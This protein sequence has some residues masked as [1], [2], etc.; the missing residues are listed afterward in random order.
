VVRFVKGVHFDPTG[1]KRDD[2]EI[3]EDFKL[4]LSNQT[5]RFKNSHSTISKDGT[6]LAK[7]IQ[8]ARS[9]TQDWKTFFITAG[10][11]VSELKK[12]GFWRGV[13]RRNIFPR[14]RAAYQGI[15]WRDLSIDLV[16]AALRQR[17]FAQ[18][19]T[20]Q[21]CTGIDS[22]IALNYAITR[23]QKFMLLLKKRTDGEKNPPMVPTLDLDLCWHTHQLHPL[24]YRSWCADH[25]KQY[26]NHDDTIG[27]ENLKEGL[28]ATSLAWFEAYREPYTTDDLKKDYLTTGR[29]VA[30]VL[31]PLYGLHVLNKSKKLEKSQQGKVSREFW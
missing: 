4:I 12:A 30:G 6:H 2:N 5:L 28:R 11:T 18:K 15:V 23:Y 29:K 3:K 14:M 27:K 1:R 26:I 13:S 17:G 24:D 10:Y 22:P 20:G 9:Q 8:D 16:A 31:M 25:L 7:Y 19:I 21:E